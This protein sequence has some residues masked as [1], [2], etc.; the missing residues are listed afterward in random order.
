MKSKQM[1]SL[2]AA[3]AIKCT[4]ANGYN[5][6]ATV[7]AMNLNNK[8]RATFRVDNDRI[9]FKD[10]VVMDMTDP[11]QNPAIKSIEWAAA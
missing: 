2:W 8:H 3:Y 10:T 9:M 4:K 7:A 5:L 6:K 11:A 1:V